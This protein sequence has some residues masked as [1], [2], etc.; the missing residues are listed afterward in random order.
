[1]PDDIDS[2]SFLK[3]GGSKLKSIFLVTTSRSVL[4]I[5][6]RS[7]SGMRIESG[8]GLYYG[9]ARDLEFT[10]IAA[11]NRLASSTIPGEQERGEILVLD[12][13]LNYVNSLR[14]PFPMR[15][16]HQILAHDGK[17]WATCAFDNMIAVYDKRKWTQW[18]PCGQS[19]KNPADVNH[20]NSLS[21]F[22]DKLCVVAHNRGPSELMLFHL[23]DLRRARNIE[24]GHSAHNAWM[25]Q[26]E[27][28][29][30]SS[31]EGCIL[32]VAGTRVETGGFP[33]GI[34][35]FDEE[36][37]VGL[38]KRIE[39]SERDFSNASILVLNRRW[40]QLR[41][42][43]LP[44]EGMVLDLMPTDISVWSRVVAAGNF[45]HVSFPVNWK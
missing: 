16:L 44:G 28:M 9:I 21:I 38:S 13:G 35:H 42:I 36:V 23:P 37:Y 14:A 17:L 27:L 20:F 25:D 6:G 5:D 18:F 12:D 4:L 1:M 19:D 34:A 41:S 30:C 15:D 43:D 33:R 24:L 2:E 10:Y 39:R 8:K 40:Q 11:R 3:S 26:D 7:A 45:E 22:G 29:I 32:G 31:E